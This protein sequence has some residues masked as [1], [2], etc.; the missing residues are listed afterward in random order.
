MNELQWE[1]SLDVFTISAS[2]AAL[3]IFLY[4]TLGKKIMKFLPDID[5]KEKISKIYTELHPNGGGSIKDTINRIELRLVNVEQKQNVYLLEG[6]QGIFEADKNGRYITVN[7]TF[8]RMV[9]KTEKELLGMGWMNSINKDDREEVFDAWMTAVQNKME[10]IGKF[11]IINNDD[12]IV[13]V[14]T[15]AYPMENPITKEIIGWIGTI[16]KE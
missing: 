8:C 6:P 14:N 16:T 9:N 10:F 15:I 3:F 4:K 12:N 11:K 7:R 1:L 13:Q 5:T 2:I